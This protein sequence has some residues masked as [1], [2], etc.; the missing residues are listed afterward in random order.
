MQEEQEEEKLWRNISKKACVKFYFRKKEN[1]K[2]GK[3]N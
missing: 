3:K 2:K 1:E